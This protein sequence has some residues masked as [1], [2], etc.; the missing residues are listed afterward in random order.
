MPLLNYLKRPFVVAAVVLCC[1]SLLCE[2]RLRLAVDALI[3]A[4]Q[5]R[6]NCWTEESSKVA[7]CNELA[8]LKPTDANYCEEAVSACKARGMYENVADAE[9]HHSLWQRLAAS[10]RL[11]WLAAILG[12]LIWV[13]LVRPVRRWS[14]P[15][16]R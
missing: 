5:A 1:A 7:R 8:K 2:V 11:A 14:E 12:A 6:W 15:V 13:G 4:H 9:A 16:G 3:Q 10:A